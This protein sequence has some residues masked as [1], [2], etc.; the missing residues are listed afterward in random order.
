MKIAISAFF[1]LVLVSAAAAAQLQPEPGLGDPRL[2]TVDYDSAQIVQLR[3]A[4]GYQL[5]VELSPD[6]QV[7]NVAIGDSSAWQVSVNRA[8]NHLFV[9]PTRSDVSTNMTVITSVRVYNFELFPQ[10]AP[11]TDMA[12]NVRFRYPLRA[13]QQPQ[14][15][16][17]DVSPALRRAS[18]YRI[19]GDRMLRPMSVSDDGAHTYVRWRADQPLPAVYEIATNGN[20]QLV[21]GGMRGDDYVIDSISPRLVFRIDGNVARADRLPPAKRKHR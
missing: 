10:P 2:Q 12:W 9:K 3:G 15:E 14:G 11:S 18:R 21:N 19:S 20:E 7:Q 5:T 8:G 17:V 4:P 13:A 1:G 6:E 16:F